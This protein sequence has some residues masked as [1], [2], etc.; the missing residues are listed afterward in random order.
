[1]GCCSTLDPDGEWRDVYDDPVRP[2][3]NGWECPPDFL[4]ICSWTLI[5]VI[6]VLHY[7]MQ[8]AFMEGVL[9]LV[10]IVI[11][12]C[13]VGCIVV[14]KITLELYHQEDPVVFR[15]DLPRLESEDLAEENAPEGMEPCVFCRRFVSKG[16]KHCSVCDKCVPGFDHHCR[17][18]NS[19]VGVK[20]YR[21]FA[22]FMASAFV[23]MMW[24]I[25]ISLYTIIVC[26]RDRDAFEAAHMRG[27]PYY[28]PRHAFPA[29]VVFNFVCL[30]LSC[31][32]AVAVGKLIFFHVYLHRT[33]QTTYEHILKKRQ[34]QKERGEYHQAHPQVEEGCCACVA[35]KRRRD[36]KRHSK[37][38]AAAAAEAA[39]AAPRQD[40][41]PYD[42]TH[43]TVSDAGNTETGVLSATGTWASHH[44]EPVPAR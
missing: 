34:R 6:A 22:F 17:W 9:F 13:C 35:L 11:T 10:T 29:I 24:V 32:G 7:T 8:I 16:S 18:L 3:R 28:S 41:E 42:E 37:M 19:C 27:H 31:M 33:H 30:G 26:L 5:I 43:G 4:Q 14:S 39:A 25:A 21:L 20:N 2:R 36:F 40:Y 44:G 15:K 12:S 23:G 1:M 38:K